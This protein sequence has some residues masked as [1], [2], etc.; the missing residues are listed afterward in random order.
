MCTYIFCEREAD[1][2]WPDDGTSQW[3]LCGSHRLAVNFALQDTVEP[4]EVVWQTMDREKRL[5][6]VPRRRP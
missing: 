2:P 6:V 4:K 5:N 1:D 3:V